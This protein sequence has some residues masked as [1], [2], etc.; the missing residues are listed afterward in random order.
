MMT[1]SNVSKGGGL[2]L[3]L[4]RDVENYKSSRIRR[5]A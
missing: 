2:T 5:K 3:R 4:K 1:V